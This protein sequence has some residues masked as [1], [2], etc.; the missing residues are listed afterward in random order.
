MHIA[1][2]GNIG[3]GK[4]TLAAKLS[5]YFDWDVSYESV[6]DNPYLEDFYQDMKRWAFHLQI[7]FLNHRYRQVEW[8]RQ[9]PKPT[10]QDRSIYEDAFIFAKTLTEH[11]QMC[12][13]D[14]Q[15]YLKVFEVLTQH[16]P[17]PDLLIYLRA[18]LDT[19]KAHIKKRG[20]EFESNISDDYLLALNRNYEAWITQYNVGPLLVLPV[21]RLNYVDR[22]DDWEEARALVEEAISV[23]Q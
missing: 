1:I 22:V 21:D 16:I 10:I 13:R 19:L 7:Y 18:D 12:P 6:E 8:A 9:N 11:E 5:Q 23:R 3:A 15:N 4:T 20:R 2:A 14:Y 17:P